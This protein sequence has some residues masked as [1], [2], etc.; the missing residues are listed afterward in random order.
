MSLGRG[1]AVSKSTKHR[2]NTKSLTESELVSPDDA[3]P[4]ILWCLYF[5]EALGYLVDQNIV[6][7]DN[8]STMRLA[9]NGSLLSSS[10]TKHIKARY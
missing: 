10:H 7:Q 4:L 2:I 1:A 5:I 8:M 3:L 9:I 6:Y